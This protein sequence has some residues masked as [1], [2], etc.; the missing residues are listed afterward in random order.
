[1]PSIPYVLEPAGHGWRLAARGFIWYFESRLK[2]I[3]FALA[4]ARDFARATGQATSVRLLEDGDL[5][6]LR[7][8]TGHGHPT[9]RSITSL[10]MWRAGWR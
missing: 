7:E 6:E 2:A 4:T 10:A 5:R 1:M 8:F 3:A 9:L